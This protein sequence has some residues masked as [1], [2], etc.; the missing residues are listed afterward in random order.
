MH[1]S[2]VIRARLAALA[3][4]ASALVVI[5]YLVA[6][7]TTRG[8]ELDNAAW[9]GRH[10]ATARAA[11][12][13]RI[14]L[15]TVS[16]TSLAV[17]LAVLIVVAYGRGRPRLALVV[18]AAVFG[19]NVTT[20]VLKH[21]VLERPVL[22]AH[23]PVAKN[24]FPSGHS[25]VA[26]SVAVAA[27]LVAPRHWRGAVGVVGFV[28]ASAVGSAT[29]IVGWHRPSDVIAGFAVAT[30]WA[31]AGA[32][33]LVVSRG[34]G[35]TVPVAPDTPQLASLITAIGVGLVVA[36]IALLVGVVGRS[37][38]LFV[39]DR[40]RAF[41]AAGA[42]IGAAAALLGGALLGALRDVTLDPPP[43]TLS[44]QRTPLARSGR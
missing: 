26:M 5:A 22:L 40:T 42:S 2:T 10:A 24:T 25:T 7:R 41:L 39:L 17:A 16:V 27:V 18:G 28:Y 44:P 37:D 32:L 30:S 4:G 8:Q 12:A 15:G 23:A 9:L 20:E 11:H 29:L 38:E 21:F 19:A 31:A 35:S 13:A 3:A 34:P 14:V 43:S 6:V 36:A 33:V 1:R